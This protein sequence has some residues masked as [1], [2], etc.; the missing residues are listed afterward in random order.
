[1]LFVSSVQASSEYFHDKLGFTVDFLYGDPPF[2]G[3]VSRGHARLH[4]RFVHQPVLTPEVRER[5]ESLLSAYFEVENLKSLFAEYKATGATFA[6]RLKKEPW[7]A[8]SFIVLDPDR[9]LLYFC[10]PVGDSV[11]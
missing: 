5:E 3:S 10:E 11:A 2:Y 8:S 7:G 6:Q 9:N 4:L 1:M